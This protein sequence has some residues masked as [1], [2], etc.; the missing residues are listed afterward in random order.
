MSEIITVPVRSVNTITTEIISIA[1]QAAQVLLLSACEMGKRMLEAKELTGHGGWGEYLEGLCDQLGISKSTAHNWMKLAQEYGEIPNFQTFGNLNYSQAVKLL[2]L[3]AQE[4]EEFVQA[5]DVEDM[6]ARELE[7]A[8][9]EKKEALAAAE[10]LQ[11]ELDRKTA[12]NQSLSKQVA[13]EA[14]SGNQARKELEALR[15]K[16]AISEADREKIREEGAAAA[17]A[18]LSGQMET[19]GKALADAQRQIEEL[20]KSGDT[21]LQVLG[22]PDGAAFEVYIGEL[23]GIINKMHGHYLKAKGRNPALTEK[24]VRAFRGI[25]TKLDELTKQM[26]VPGND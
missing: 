8:I 22:D 23:S 26:E 19:A 21:Q 16:P 7:Q 15:A 14:A 11:E 2:A 4:R 24:M 9:R 6:S 12:E 1:N 25:T 17:R 13:A 20:K 18:L 5:H 3:P 10:K